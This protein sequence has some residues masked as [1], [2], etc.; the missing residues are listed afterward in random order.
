MEPDPNGWDEYGSYCDLEGPAGYL[1]T[2]VDAVR[3]AIADG[4]ILYLEAVDGYAAAGRG[5]RASCR[6]SVP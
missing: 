5:P 4:T 1:G 6:G 3:W 2:T